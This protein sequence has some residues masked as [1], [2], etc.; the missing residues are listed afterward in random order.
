M[1]SIILYPY[2]QFICVKW[3]ILLYIEDNAGA[4]CHL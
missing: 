3:A 1:E 4:N 2:D